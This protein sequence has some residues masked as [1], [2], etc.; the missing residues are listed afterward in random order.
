[1]M[2]SAEVATWKNDQDEIYWPG[3]TVW[4]KDE[5]EYVPD[6]VEFLISMVTLK[7]SSEGMSS[8]LNLTLPGVYNGEIPEVLPWQQ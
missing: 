4:V 1:V 7:R 6:F 2:G 8:F 3:Q 5:A